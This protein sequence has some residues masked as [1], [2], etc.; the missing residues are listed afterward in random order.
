MRRL[1]LP[2][3]LLPQS[4]ISCFLILACMLCIVSIPLWVLNTDPRPH[5]IPEPNSLNFALH[6]PYGSVHDRWFRSLI[7][8][9]RYSITVLSCFICTINL[10]ILYF[11]TFT[12]LLHGSQD[13]AEAGSP[14][15]HFDEP[16]G[17]LSNQQ[18]IVPA[19]DAQVPVPPIN[20]VLMAGA[21]ELLSAFGR[22]S[23]IHSVADAP[24]D[25]QAPAVVAAPAPALAPAMD[26]A[27]PAL[28]SLLKEM[29]NLLKDRPQTTTSN[30]PK[31]HHHRLTK[32]SLGLNVVD[33]LTPKET[34]GL[35]IMTAEQ[36][37]MANR[38]SKTDWASQ[39]LPYLEGHA[40]QALK[41]FMGPTA[42]PLT[43][44]NLKEVL[45]RLVEGSDDSPFDLLMRIVDF[46][47]GLACTDTATASSQSLLQGI[48][49]W[50]NLI[51]RLPF[52][53][54]EPVKCFLLFKALPSTLRPFV[55]HDVSSGVPKEWTEYNRMRTNVLTHS[56]A[57]QE[58]IKQ[59]YAPQ[60]KA[61]T[62][63]PVSNKRA[64]NDEVSRPPPS[65]TATV[66]DPP[67]NT[68]YWDPV[69]R[70]ALSKRLLTPP[71]GSEGK[72]TFF[73]QGLT[74]AKSDALKNQ[75]KCLVCEK[76]GH[77][78]TDCPQREDLYNSGKFFYYAKSL[79]G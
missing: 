34:L 12:D 58:H 5:S 49:E 70:V 33:G 40:K 1:P 25:P 43:W 29:V 19:D 23:L 20:D 16:E 69:T 57:F 48:V 54:P 30:A 66:V 73:R 45:F 41:E 9:V 22:L 37:F 39:A 38:T 77:R 6:G 64:R 53:L 67:S 47:I 55:R 36:L 27:E 61:K 76:E 72:Y 44:E 17:R 78:V 7:V 24:Q 35:W 14:S 65:S 71:L 46:S 26:P 11:R 32:L 60:L 2:T 28:V 75:K 18:E 13:M 56:G 15:I 62:D 79:R 31:T 8:P 59:H 74:R 50:E 52:V 63:A 10:I 42:R 68:A 21:E 4:S 51:A 3:H